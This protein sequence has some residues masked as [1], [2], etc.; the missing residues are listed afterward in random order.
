MSVAGDADRRS[1]QPM[2]INFGLFP[3]VEIPL[4][5]EGKRYKGKTKSLARKRAVSSRALADL[6]S[7]LAPN[8][9]AAE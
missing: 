3:A 6:E 9:I 2:N 8:R 4:S 5:P 7:W 1:F